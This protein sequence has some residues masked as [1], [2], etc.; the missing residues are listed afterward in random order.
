MC[1]CV[2]ECCCLRAKDNGLYNRHESNATEV[3]SH[4]EIEGTRRRIDG[5]NGRDGLNGFLKAQNYIYLETYL[6]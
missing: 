5:L 1:V 2:H 4:S 3:D 6:L